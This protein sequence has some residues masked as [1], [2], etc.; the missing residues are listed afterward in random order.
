[1]TKYISINYETIKNFF[2]PM[3]IMKMAIKEDDDIH[4]N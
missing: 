3:T 4:I 2:E 1:M